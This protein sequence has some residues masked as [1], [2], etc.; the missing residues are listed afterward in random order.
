MSS[1][2]C[3]TTPPTPTACSDKPGSH[4][5]QRLARD[6]QA[7]YPAGQAARDDVGAAIPSKPLTWCLVP[8]ERP[9]RTQ[10]WILSVYDCATVTMVFAGLSCWLLIAARDGSGDLGMVERLTAAVQGLFPL[11][12]ALGLR[13]T[14][15][16]AGNQGQRGQ[17]PA[18]QV[19]CATKHVPPPTQS[20]RSS[21]RWHLR[22]LSSRPGIMELKWL[23]EALSRKSVRGVT[24][25]PNQCLLAAEFALGHVA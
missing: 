16:D 25:P 20:S 2:T 10:S 4:Q 13:Q 21:L 15:R 3:R 1:K 22:Y 18:G 17:E 6:Q 14:A 12:V 8:D 24:A 9:A 5:P 23:P 7:H 11:V 19:S